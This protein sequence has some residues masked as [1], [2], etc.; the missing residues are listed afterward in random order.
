MDERWKYLIV[1]VLVPLGFYVV[2]LVLF[3]R[4][5]K[6]RRAERQR[7]ADGRNLRFTARA[8]PEMEE[9]YPFLSCLRQGSNRYA[10]NIARGSIEQR[11]GRAW[12]GGRLIAFDYHYSSIPLL[13]GQE[14]RDYFQFSVVVFEADLVLPNMLIRPASSTDRVAALFTSNDLRFES[15]RF[16][17]NFTIRCENREWAFGFISP[18]VMEFLEEHPGFTI[19]IAGH[20]LVLHTGALFNAKT[21]DDAITLGLGLLDRI[22]QDL[23]ASIGFERRPRL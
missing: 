3:Y 13:K 12:G 2:G 11:A 6:A 4:K 5:R 21:F 23:V 17:K 7:W 1:F 14:G 10:F 20:A 18:K 9:R 8:Y 16:N 22:P 15:D 19:E